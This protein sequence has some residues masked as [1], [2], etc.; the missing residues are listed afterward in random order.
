MLRALL[1]SVVAIVVATVVFG[2]GYPAL[3]TGIGAVALPH[4]ASGQGS[5]MSFFHTS[6]V[7]TRTGRGYLR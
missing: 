3:M 1:A 5:R 6:H 7:R 4:P 2:F